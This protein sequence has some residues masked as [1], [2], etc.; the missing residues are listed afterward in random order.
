MQIFPS[1][2]KICVEKLTTDNFVTP[3]GKKVFAKIKECYEA[4]GRFDIAFI[5]EEFTVDE[6][7]RITK[8]MADRQR[9]DS[10]D[11]KVLT[12]LISTLLK[13][14]DNVEDSDTVDSI[15]SAISKKKK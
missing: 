5:E 2:L 6:I 10:N 3:L 4:T 12:E 7:S 15:L 8:M 14:K 1:H 9:L 11:E 13:E